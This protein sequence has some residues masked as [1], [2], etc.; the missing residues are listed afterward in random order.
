M[1][2]YINLKASLMCTILE[3][4]FDHFFEE[5]A[6]LILSFKDDLLL[7]GV[8]INID[9]L[10][11]DIY[12]HVHEIGVPSLWLVG[13]ISCIY[14]TLDFIWLYQA[15]VYKQQ[16]V[17]LLCLDCVGLGVDAR[18]VISEVVK[19]FREIQEILASCV[20]PISLLDDLDPQLVLLSLLFFSRLYNEFIS[21]WSGYV[22]SGYI[23]FLIVHLA[24]A[25]FDHGVVNRIT[26]HDF[27]NLSVFLVQSNT[28]LPLKVII[29]HVF[30]L[31]GCAL[32]GCDGLGARAILVNQEAIYKVTDIGNVC[33][34]HF[35]S[36]CHL[37]D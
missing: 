8:Y 13:L 27:H 26:G 15:I 6:K 4:I 29:E 23:S 1:S 3:F 2:A 36:D 33:T 37:W 18:E 7:C 11:G 16:Q 14:G 12:R 34:S 35:W 20:L 21:R 17:V 10:S 19:V 25:K 9:L 28:L 5:V 22:V 24:A 32:L 31:D 30:N